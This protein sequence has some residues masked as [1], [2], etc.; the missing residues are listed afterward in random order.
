[1]LKIDSKIARCSI[2]KRNIRN[3]KIRNISILI[4]G[5]QVFPSFHPNPYLRLIVFLWPTS[6]FSEMQYQ[7]I[8]QITILNACR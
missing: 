1:M 3:E 8:Q 2:Q 6:F 7:M 5:K 4:K